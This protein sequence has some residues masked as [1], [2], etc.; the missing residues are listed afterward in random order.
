MFKVEKVTFFEDRASVCRIETLDLSSGLHTF[1]I[2]GLSPYLVDKSLVFECENQNITCVEMHAQRSFKA[3]SGHLEELKNKREKLEQLETQAAYN[4][5]SV[6]SLKFNLKQIMAKILKDS[7]RG[8]TDTENW[9][10]ALKQ[11]RKS[12]NKHLLKDKELKA[13]KETLQEEIN[14]LQIQHQEIKKEYHSEIT[15]S[16][17]VKEASNFTLK[18]HYITAGACWRPNYKAFVEDENIVFKKGASIWQNCGEEWQDILVEFSTERQQKA[19]IPELSADCLQ[20]KRKA[21]EELLIREELIEEKEVVQKATFEVPGIQDDG[22]VFKCLVENRLT[23]PSQ[24]QASSLDYEEFSSNCLKELVCYPMLTDSVN[25]IIHFEN[26]SGQALLAAPVSIYKNNTLCGLS[27]VKYSSPGQKI[28]LDLGNLPDVVVKRQEKLKH[29]SKLL[30][31]WE[32][33]KHDI[34]L[35]ISNLGS[36]EICFVMKERV[37]VSESDK[38]KIEIVEKNTSPIKFPNDKGI[39]EWKVN[40]NPYGQQSINLEYGL[41]T[42]S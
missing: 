21:S 5:N 18:V 10:E 40:L 20:T 30:S 27:E 7:N 11:L 15:L 12:E 13:A 17:D 14:E 41:K 42:S 25:E 6:A 19:Q 24:E 9:Q 38:A 2:Q 4:S 35:S 1:T 29:D 16:V 31:S 22:S 34:R 37:P 33:E 39:I 32:T 8:I 26:T 28:K 36:K 3:R 23:I